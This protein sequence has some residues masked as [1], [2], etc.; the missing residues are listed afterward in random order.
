MN[1]DIIDYIRKNR[2]D[3][4]REAITQQLLDAGYTAVEVGAAWR[5]VEGSHFRDDSPGSAE[6]PDPRY[7]QSIVNKPRFWAIFFGYIALTYSV[8]ALF[9]DV[10]I[11]NPV[12][13]SLGN[14]LLYFFVGLQLFALIF[15][16]LRVGVDRPLGM[17]LLLSVASALI[18]IPCLAVAVLWGM[19][20]GTFR[21]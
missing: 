6:G 9:V 7:N 13:G 21:A 20:T 11:I 4:T 17:G 19:C 5:V 18:V 2:D 12:P 10:T 15:G 1:P 3:Y 8:V 16:L 14:V